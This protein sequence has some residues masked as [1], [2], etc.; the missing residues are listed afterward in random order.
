MSISAISNHFREIIKDL[1]ESKND[2][3]ST[4]YDIHLNA[5]DSWHAELP[6]Y[7]CLQTPS[8]EDSRMFRQEASYQQKTA[9]L[10]VQTLFLGIV[11]E[12]LQPALMIV[13][14][15]QSSSSEND[16][17]LYARRCVQSATI[18]VRLC[19][20]IV[21]TAGSHILSAS[22]IAQHFLFNATLILIADMNR[23]DSALEEFISPEERLECIR[24]AQDLLNEMNFASP[25]AIIIRMLCRAAGLLDTTKIK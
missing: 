10:N 24:I 6:L 22:W 1:R 15:H 21:A 12:L 7:L 19:N 2:P 9:I 16:L 3:S 5:L 18:L 25:Q 8:S 4:L 23:K 17:R 11:C 20:E 13:L 14:Q